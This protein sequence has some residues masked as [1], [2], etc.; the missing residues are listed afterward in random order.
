M[1]KHADQRLRDAERTSTLNKL[2]VTRLGA[3]FIDAYLSA[4]D[5]QFILAC[6][7]PGTEQMNY[8]MRL[9]RA[10]ADIMGLY[11]LSRDRELM[12]DCRSKEE[13]A[14]K[15]RLAAITYLS[16]L[17]AAGMIDFIEKNDPQFGYDP[18]QWEDMNK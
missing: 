8:A 9:D 7:G 17:I 18:K 2:R 14:H 4:G 1:K 3:P 10:E 6:R 15:K 16:G 5:Y 13:V 11:Q 12:P